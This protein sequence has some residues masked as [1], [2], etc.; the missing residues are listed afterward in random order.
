M[1]LNCRDV[2]AGLETSL[3]L[4]HPQE[5]ILILGFELFNLGLVLDC[6]LESN[7]DSD[8]LRAMASTCVLTKYFIMG[9]KVDQRPEGGPFPRTPLDRLAPPVLRGADLEREAAGRPLGSLLFQA[10]EFLEHH[11]D[12]FLHQSAWFKVAFEIHETLKDLEW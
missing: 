7:A 5:N 8:W 9:L 4:H 6:F 10:E 3:K 2:A 12:V 1:I 11:A